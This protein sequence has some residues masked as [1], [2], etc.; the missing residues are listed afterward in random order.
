TI[1]HFQASGQKEITIGDV[2]QAILEEKN[3]HSAYFLGLLGIS[4]IDVLNFISHQIRKVPEELPQD[5][6]SPDA[7]DRTGPCDAAPSA[8]PLKHFT[9]DLVERA[10]RGKIDPLIGRREE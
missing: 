5:E 1:I 7:P 4:R 3:S 9:I 6:S 10:A 2:L 8:D